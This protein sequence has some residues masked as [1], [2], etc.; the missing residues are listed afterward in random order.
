MQAMSIPHNSAQFQGVCCQRQWNFQGHD[1]SRFQ[2][3]GQGAPNPVHGQFRG[4]TPE[5]EG[6]AVTKNMGFN[7]AVERVPGKSAGIAGVSFVVD[8][9]H[10]AVSGLRS[11]LCDFHFFRP[12][13]RFTGLEL[14]FRMTSSSSRAAAYK[15]RTE[16]MNT[17]VRR[18]VLHR[19]Q[20]LANQ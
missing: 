15:F 19:Y 8:S 4:S 7:S 11:H 20:C 17:K 9:V 2:F 3:A 12:E 10:L 1:L 6:T 18:S 13:N 16:P 14:P 5:I